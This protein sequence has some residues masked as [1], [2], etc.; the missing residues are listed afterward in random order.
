[1]KFILNH[2]WLQADETRSALVKQKVS[3]LS[4]L[5]RV[6]A[7]EVTLEK[8]EASSPP[9]VAKIHLAVPGPDLYAEERDHTLEASVH[10]VLEKLARQIRH[11]KQKRL[12]RRRSG[13]DET[14]MWAKAPSTPSFQPA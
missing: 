8:N 1:M 13:A 3:K 2:R 10:K 6:E 12:A 5:V 14:R 11:R 4:G 9:Y 7:A